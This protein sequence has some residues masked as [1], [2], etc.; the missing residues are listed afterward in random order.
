MFFSTVSEPN[1]TYQGEEVAL[2]YLLRLALLS[3][4][5]ESIP[6]MIGDLVGLGKIL[7]TSFSLFTH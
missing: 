1:I 3:P 2:Y 7:Y 4:L 5:L 6:N